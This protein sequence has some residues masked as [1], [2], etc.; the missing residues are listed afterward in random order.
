MIWREVEAASQNRPSIALLPLGATEQHGPHMPLAT[1]SIMVEWI[2]CKAAEAVDG[3]VVAPVIQYGT[4]QN[5][6]RFPGTVSLSLDTLKRTIVDVGEA[7]LGHGFD[8]LMLVNGHGG[9]LAAMSAA[10][11]V[12]REK[13]GRV[14][15]A[16]TWTALVREAWSCFESPV[17][18]HADESETSL[19]LHIAPDLVRMEAAKDE[20]PPP[21]PFFEFTE[22]ALLTR[23]IDLGLP[24]THRI[25]QSGTI[26]E[27]RRAGADKGGQV[28]AEA[29]T[30]L[31][32]TLQ[33]LR[34]DGTELIHWMTEA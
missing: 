23:G 27:A 21:I 6:K 14:V 1:D 26:G 34:K 12:L 5:H 33:R 16:L 22:E 19:M 20:L 7:L 13:T 29:V 31:I 24:P 17:I 30:N 18:W 9:N 3:V 2:C 10:A 28:V 8:I 25:S 15:A 32:Q 4:S 11:H